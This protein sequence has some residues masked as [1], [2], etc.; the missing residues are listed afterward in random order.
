MWAIQT[1]PPISI[2]MLKATNSH[3]TASRFARMR[4]PVIST[5]HGPSHPESARGTEQQMLINLRQFDVGWRNVR[6]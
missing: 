6:Q 5:V 1:A 3:H 4:M 2:R